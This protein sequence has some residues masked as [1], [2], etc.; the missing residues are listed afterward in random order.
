MKVTVCFGRTRVVVPCGDGNIK[1]HILILQAVMRY[2]KAIAKVSRVYFVWRV[3]FQC[4]I[5]SIGSGNNVA[6]PGLDVRLAQ[7]WRKF[8]RDE[9]KMTKLFNMPFVL[10][11]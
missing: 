1:I 2:K 7:I 6:M 4:S 10:S 3:C 11:C 9:L 5:Y 8:V